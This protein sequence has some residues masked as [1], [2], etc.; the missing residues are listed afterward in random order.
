MSLAT[1][2]VL[3]L[4][5]IAL[6]PAHAAGDDK[7]KNVVVLM[8]ENRAF[9]HML[10]WITKSRP[11]VNG[12][13]GRE[14]NP[15]DPSVPSSPKVFVSDDAVY[16]D[17]Y[18]PDH[19]YEGTRSEVFGDAM[20][21]GPPAPMS[22]FVHVN[23][24]R[25]DGGMVMRGFTSDKVP[26]ITTL[27]NEF[28]LFDRWF[29][30]VPGPTNPNR[31]FLHAATADGSLDNADYDPQ[32]FTARTVFDA[33][34]DVNISWGVYFED[35]SPLCMFQSLRT[36]ANKAR[37]FPMAEFYS[38]AANGSLPRYAF[39]EPRMFPTDTLPANDQHPDHDVRDGEKLMRDVYLALRA[40]PLWTNML[41]LITYDEHG[42]YFDHVP[43]PLAVPS[44][45]GKTD[46]SSGFNFTR[47]GVRVPA[48]LISPWIDKGILVRDA[49]AA[50]KPTPTSE[51]EHSSL[52]ATFAKLFGIPLLTKRA[53]WASTFE[54]VWARQTPRT[55]CPTTLP[56]VPE[57]PVI[58]V[59][60]FATRPLN[61]LQLS[62][63][64]QINTCYPSTLGDESVRR[65][66]LQ[67]L[68]TLSQARAGAA[69]SAIFRRYLQ[70]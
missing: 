23:G 18:D 69:V 4:L 47:L 60:H 64:E 56:P 65:A 40:S 46:A 33:L 20:W 3:L 2:C 8:E 38:Q 21:A 62:M 49:P 27:A 54:H 51:Y 15:K 30:S 66:E 48:L 36:P 12:L 70:E 42:G 41:Y 61:D 39:I 34:N 50:Q 67:R 43:T 11:E 25:G 57:E 59:A 9:D 5:L 31:R 32:G 55:D 14:F 37:F 29:C 68:S 58:P 13:T 6:A 7:I 17:A 16:V 10:G 22:G 26:I 19:S 28:A 45:D 24:E 52:P 35:W 53:E 44:P 1:R 63:M